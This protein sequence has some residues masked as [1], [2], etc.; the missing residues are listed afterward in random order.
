MIFAA[1]PSA[2]GGG[3]GWKTPARERGGRERKTPPTAEKP[4]R[5]VGERKNTLRLIRSL[6]KPGRAPLRL[7]GK[8]GSRPARRPEKPAPPPGPLGLWVDWDAARYA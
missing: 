6:K 5:L 4:R 2:I 3:V 1:E 8:T 7:D